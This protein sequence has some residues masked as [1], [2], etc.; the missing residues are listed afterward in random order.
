MW[1]YWLDSIAAQNKPQLTCDFINL[2]N[3]QKRRQ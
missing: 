1:Y 2:Q 3:M